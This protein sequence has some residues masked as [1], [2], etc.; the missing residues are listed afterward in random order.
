MALI[1]AC[2]LACD[3]GS[4]QSL[5]C[6]LDGNRVSLDTVAAQVAIGAKP[7]AGSSLV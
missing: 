6:C 7:V 5:R 4:A 1:C 2:L 3:C